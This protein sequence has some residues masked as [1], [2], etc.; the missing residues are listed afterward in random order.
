[1]RRLT[2]REDV[3]PIRGTFAIARGSRTQARVVV[4]EIAEEGLP[5]GRSVG[6][7]NVFPRPDMGKASIR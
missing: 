1:M 7:E 6:A 5:G 2:V 3:L 4:A